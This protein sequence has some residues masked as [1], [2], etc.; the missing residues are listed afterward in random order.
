MERIVKILLIALVLLTGCKVTRKATESSV[1]KASE[2]TEA[3]R[4]V[5]EVKD[6]RENKD[7]SSVVETVTEETVT[8]FY[9]PVAKGV[10]PG[11][12][13]VEPVVKTGAVKSLRT[14]RTLRTEKESDKSKVGVSG[15]RNEAEIL[16]NDK[17][18]K[19]V[20]DFKVVKKTGVVKWKVVAGIAALLVG[21][22]LLV[23]K[24]VVNIPFLAK[25]VNWIS[26][27]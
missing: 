19:E 26:G 18:S 10:E 7:V 9:E 24:R 17:D 20:K 5:K 2:Q 23:K 12:G 1:I 21:L 8:E 22:Y 27:L 13:G 11:A 25:V 6:F 16:K 4:T 15:E 3:I 14:I